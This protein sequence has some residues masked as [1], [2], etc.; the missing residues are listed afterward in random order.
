M[1]VYIYIIV[2]IELPTY[3][4]YLIPVQRITVFHNHNVVN[5]IQINFQPNMDK[6]VVQ[7]SSPQPCDRIFTTQSWTLLS[8]WAH[9]GPFGRASRQGAGPAQELLVAPTQWRSCHPDVPWNDNTPLIKSLHHTLSKFQCHFDKR[10]RVNWS[11]GL[12]DTFRP[13]CWC[14]HVPICTNVVA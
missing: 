11:L 12:W 10:G 14:N 3:Y 1:Y 13:P 8:D 9:S 6:W 2:Y 4:S 5:P 7:S